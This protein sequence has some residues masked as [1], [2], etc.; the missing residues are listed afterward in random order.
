[1][2]NELTMLLRGR[3]LAQLRDATILSYGSTNAASEHSFSAMRLIK[4]Y[5]RSMMTQERLN[6]LMTLYVHKEQTDSLSL[7]NVANEFVSTCDRR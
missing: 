1:M 7:P 5:L 6:H 4:S 3:G 2:T